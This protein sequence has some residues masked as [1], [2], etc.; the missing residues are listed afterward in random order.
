MKI[1]QGAPDERTSEFT[2]IFIRAPRFVQETI[3]CEPVAYLEN[4]VVGV[5]QDN[6]LALTFHPELTKD[7]RFHR[8][9][10]ARIASSKMVD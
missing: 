10:I 4:E 7:R 3:N 6:K 2:G 1:E 8:W 5:L 9:L